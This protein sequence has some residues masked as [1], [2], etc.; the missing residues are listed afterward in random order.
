MT[1]W[2]TKWQLL[3]AGAKLIVTRNVYHWSEWYT[4]FKSS[5]LSMHL[6][7]KAVLGERYYSI[8]SRAKVSKRCWLVWRPSLQSKGSSADLEFFQKPSWRRPGKPAL[9]KSCATFLHFLFLV[10]TSVP[11]LALRARLASMSLWQN[12]GYDFEGISGD[13][14]YDL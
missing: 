1:D 5:G 12:S 8:M 6:E 14:W 13:E 10:T 9:A 7:W 4:S 3:R 11:F 2:L